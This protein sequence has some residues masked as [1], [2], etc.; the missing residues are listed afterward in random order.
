MDPQDQSF[1][2]I[3]GCRKS[4]CRAIEVLPPPFLQQTELLGSETTPV[5]TTTTPP[6]RTQAQA[7]ALSWRRS[8]AKGGHREEIHVPLSVPNDQP[9]SL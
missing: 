9:T 8:D 7:Q 2:P 3:E 1:S 5:K 6:A 4:R